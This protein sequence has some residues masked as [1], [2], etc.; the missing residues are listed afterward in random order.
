MVIR[1][2]L[3]IANTTPF[4]SEGLNLRKFPKTTSSPLMNLVSLYQKV[5]MMEL[6]LL[7]TVPANNQMNED[8]LHSP[9]I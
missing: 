4:M 9:I 1:T 6:C 5:L 8:S 7:D 2:T 3:F